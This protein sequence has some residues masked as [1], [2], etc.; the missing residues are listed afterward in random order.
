MDPKLFSEKIHSLGKFKTRY[1]GY[2][3]SKT[4]AYEDL[5]FEAH[6]QDCKLCD[7]N[8][9]G[10]LIFIEIKFLKGNKIKYRQKCLDCKKVWQK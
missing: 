5:V 3:T 8:N 7:R 4:V 9:A 6:A 2:T 10:N 1:R